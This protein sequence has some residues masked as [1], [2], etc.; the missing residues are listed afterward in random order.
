MTTLALNSGFQNQTEI[1]ALAESLFNQNHRAAIWGNVWAKLRKQHTSLK[2]LNAAVTSTTIKTTK[3]AKVELKAI[4]GNDADGRV[5]D[6]DAQFRPLKTHSRA[7]WISVAQAMLR[8]TS[9][10]PVALVEVGHQ[11]FV[12]DGHHRLSVAQAMGQTTINAHV[13]VLAA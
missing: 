12:Q 7:R 5:Q 6:F 3:Q 4:V 8:G 1:K 2:S 10:P 13:V 9:L 11:Y